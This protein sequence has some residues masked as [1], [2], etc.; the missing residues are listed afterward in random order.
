MI[1]VV[2]LSLIHISAQGQ[3]NMRRIRLEA[4]GLDQ[5]LYRAARLSLF[6]QRRAE[7]IKCGGTERLKLRFHAILRNCRGP[8]T[9]GGEDLSKCEVHIS[10]CLLYTSRCV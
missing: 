2:L 5:F 9:L 3:K 6:K 4:I 10:R 8:L 7:T 1:A